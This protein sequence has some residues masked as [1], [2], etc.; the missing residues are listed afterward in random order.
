MSGTRGLI[1]A[2]NGALYGRARVPFDGRAGSVYRLDPATGAVTIIHAFLTDEFDSRPFALTRTSD[3]LLYGVR[4]A[5]ASSGAGH[6]FRVDPTT[7]TVTEVVALDPAGA[8]VDPASPLVEAP[9]GSLYGTTAGPEDGALFRVE[10]LRAAPTR[11][12]SSAGS[13][14]SSTGTDPTPRLVLASD[15][16]FYG[17]MAHGGSW[18]APR[19]AAARSFASIVS[20]G[21]RPPIRGSSRFSRCSRPAVTGGVPSVRPSRDRMARSTG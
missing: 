10:R 14:A 13:H 8:A 1:E 18:A 21:E 15:G 12:R 11:S 7:D 16:W 6:I 5:G 4:G 19:W 3:G 2:P 17:A 20:G 9:D